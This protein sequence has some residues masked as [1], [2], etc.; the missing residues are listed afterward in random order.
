MMLRLAKLGIATAALVVL[1][2]PAA[3]AGVPDVTVNSF[4]VPQGG[5]LATPCD[6]LTGHCCE[7]TT[8]NCA[9]VPANGN[10]PSYSLTIG[11]GAVGL[12][13]HCPDLDNSAQELRN[14]ARLKVVVKTS[15]GT[16][17]ANIAA[18]DIC[19]MFNG[20]RPGAPP[21]GQGFDG[22]GADSIQAD[23]Q[24]SGGVAVGCPALRCIPADAPTDA[25]GVTYITWIGHR[26]TDAAG[27]G[28]R[29]PQRKWGGYD[30]N[31][32]VMVL[33]YQLQGRLTSGGAQ[34]SYKCIVRSFDS[35]GY[36]GLVNTTERVTFLD[37]NPLGAKAFKADFDG[38]GSVGITDVNLFTPHLN[39]D[40]T[41]P[42]RC[43][44]P[45]PN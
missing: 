12:A 25:D 39:S 18:A 23:P 17:I 27:V 7:G 33:G 1:I 37:N 15:D 13:R 16:P 3:Y 35:E 22:N 41:Q 20:G 21:G 40:S 34:G 11:G 24:W 36:A 5:P 29:D 28:N 19:V 43:N 42:H 8:G 44:F 6:G 2:V 31:I 38:N 45:N 14:W 10:L 30:S 26:P 4:F 32:P 9:A